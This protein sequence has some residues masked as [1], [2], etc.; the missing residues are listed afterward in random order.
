MIIQRKSCVKQYTKLQCIQHVNY[1]TYLNQKEKKQHT[2]IQKHT[3]I[4]KDV[5]DISQKSH[6]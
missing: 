1:F 5:D 3:N 2:D 4:R 6:A